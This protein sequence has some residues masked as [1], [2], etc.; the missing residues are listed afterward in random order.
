METTKTLA[1]LVLVFCLIPLGCDDSR[2]DD[3]IPQRFQAFAQA[4]EQERVAL[5]AT[6]TPY[7]P[8]LQPTSV[9]NFMVTAQG[10]PR[11]LTFIADGNGVYTYIRSRP[12]LAARTSGSP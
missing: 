7:T 5:D 4:V 12:Y 2:S 10:A 3:A 6:N 1:P 11:P 9:D 8:Q